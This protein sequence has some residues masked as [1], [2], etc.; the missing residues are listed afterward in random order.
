MKSSEKVQ[1]YCCEKLATTKDHIPPKC[2]FPGKKQPSSGSPDYRVNL[3]T[4][5]ACAEHNNSRSIDDEYTAAVVIMNSRSDLAS[6]MFKSKWV[7]TLLGREDKGFLGKRIFSTARSAKVIS[8]K[9]SILIPHK[10]LAISYEMKRIERVIESIARALYYVESGYQEK[11]TNSCVI[12]SPNFL[13]RDL[14]YSQDAHTL[15]QTN[16]AFIHGEKYQELGLTRKGLNP[17]IFYYQFLK[18][19]DKNL[20]IRMVFY[21]DFVFLAFLTERETAPSP[22]ILAI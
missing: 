20:I 5:P 12:R 1:C 3:I 10:T 6:T 2:F 4:V 9:N 17:D 19:E 22:I 14:S 16:Q 21:S 18:S 15:D 11:W 13:N 7:H 8:N